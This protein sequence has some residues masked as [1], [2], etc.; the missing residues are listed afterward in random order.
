[1]TGRGD[2]RLPHVKVVASISL[3]SPSRWRCGAVRPGRSARRLVLGS[4]GWSGGGTSE[5]VARWPMCSTHYCWWADSPCWRCA[6]WAGAPVSAADV[7][8]KVVGGVAALALLFYVA[9]A[10]LGPERF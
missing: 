5:G 3:V 7:V 6:S 8:T 1:M 9:I 10:L 2:G 4:A